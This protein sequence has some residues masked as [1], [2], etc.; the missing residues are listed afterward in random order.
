ML[1]YPRVLRSLKERGWI[2]DEQTVLIL[3]GGDFDR[4]CMLEAGFKNVTISN[5]DYHAGHKD[6]AP[7]EWKRLDAERIELDQDAYDWVVIHGG[8]HHLAV[9]AMGVC[10]MFRVARKGILCFEARDSL[11]MK[12]A[13]SVGLTAEYELESAFLAGGTHGGYRNGPIPNYVYRWK[14][15]EFEKVVNSFAPTHKHSFFYYYGFHVPVER[16][17]MARSPLYRF[18][19]VAISKLTRAA[20]AVIPK[21]GNQFAFG[22]RKNTSLQPW[23]TPDLRFN[24]SFM[25]KRY[26][27]SL[28]RRRDR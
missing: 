9:P 4:Q 26:D 17:A 19:G 21:Q 2:A 24:D 6:Y 22:V 27:K 14:E 7:Y 10:E 23:L 20:E 11:L 3:A 13:V 8:L 25:T 5:L 12:L 16:F 1:L 28:Y 18:A 15:R